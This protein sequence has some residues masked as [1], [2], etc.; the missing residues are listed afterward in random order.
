MYKIRPLY[1]IIYKAC[2]LQRV[3]VVKILKRSF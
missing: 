1:K 3:Y 2:S